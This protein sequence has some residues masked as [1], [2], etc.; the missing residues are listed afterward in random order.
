MTIKWINKGLCFLSS[1]E[2]ADSSRLRN[3][4]LLLLQNIFGNVYNKY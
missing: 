4:Q 1:L 3:S 2:E